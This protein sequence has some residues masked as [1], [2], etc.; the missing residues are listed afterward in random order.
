[1]SIW[2]E[3]REAI[4]ALVMSFLVWFG[5][6]PV[7]IDVPEQSLGTSTGQVVQVIDGDTI[8][9]LFDQGSS[10]VRVR[11]I[12]IN[13]PEPY[14]TKNPECGSSEA[15]VRNRELV[16][17]QTVTIVPGTEPY[18]SYGRLLAY[19]YVGEK[20]IN[21][22]LVAEGF[23]EIMMIPPN[24]EYNKQFTALQNE[25]KTQQRGAWGLCR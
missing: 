19:V 12:G 14:A 13:T 23:A 15:S 16:E 5:G 7:L 11:Y 10:T 25:A 8:D 21:E 18:D 24:T 4:T 17:A 6:A 9:V 2:L 22:I 20:F 3:I 1:M